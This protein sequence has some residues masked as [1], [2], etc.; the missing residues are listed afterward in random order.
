M[1]LV[2]YPPL[3]GDQRGWS[4]TTGNLSMFI[5]RIYKIKSA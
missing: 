4:G 2:T 1:W 3:A 5:T